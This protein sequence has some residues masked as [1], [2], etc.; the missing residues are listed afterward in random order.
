MKLQI[1]IEMQL[2]VFNI[3]IH[4]HLFANNM[5]LGVQ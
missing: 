1:K 3:I 2:I 5:Q 4:Y